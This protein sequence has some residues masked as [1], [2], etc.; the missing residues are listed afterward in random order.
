MTSLAAY[1]ERV[2]AGELGDDG[3]LQL[4]RP[5][6]RG[7]VEV[8]ALDRRVRRRAN[9]RP[10]VEVR[11]ARREADHLAALTLELEH[12]GGDGERRGRLHLLQAA[13]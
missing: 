5:A 1:F 3:V 10:R 9:V 11:L 13:G 8:A 2:V 4:G 12:L 6:H 7:V